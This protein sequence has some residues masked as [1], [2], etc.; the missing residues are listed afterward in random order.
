MAFPELLDMAAK[1]AADLGN[2]G[3][4]MLGFGM[5]YRL[6]IPVPPGTGV[7]IPLPRVS[8]ET[9]ARLVSEI[10]HKG[11]AGFTLDALR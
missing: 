6:L 9:R 11:P 1:W 2:P 4:A 3:K 10:D 5:F 8:K 7:L